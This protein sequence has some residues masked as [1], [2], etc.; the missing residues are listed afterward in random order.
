[1]VLQT[2]GLLYRDDVMSEMKDLVDERK[3]REEDD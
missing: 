3:E 1:V 2:G